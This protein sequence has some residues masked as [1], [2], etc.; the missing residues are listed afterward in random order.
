MSTPNQTASFDQL[1]QSLKTETPFANTESAPVAD[2]EFTQVL[3]LRL[4]TPL[5]QL[6]SEEFNTSLN[7]SPAFGLCWLAHKQLPVRTGS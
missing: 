7:F 3:R 6:N 1:Q 5:R 4:L 2:L